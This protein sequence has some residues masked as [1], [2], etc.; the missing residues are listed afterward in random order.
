[1]LVLFLNKP[2]SCSYSF[3]ARALYLDT[4][5]QG[6]GSKENSPLYSM[7]YHLPPGLSNSACLS[8]NS[9]ASGCLSL[10]ALKTVL[11]SGCCSGTLL[12]FFFPSAAFC[13]LFSTF[14]SFASFLL[15][16]SFSLVHPLQSET[17]SIW[18]NSDS[19]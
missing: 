16:F 12:F 9:N 5:S 11:L 18:P 7:S 6:C 3:S 19:E 17:S 4:T 15:V 8:R 13:F 14:G 2:T 1:M 10:F